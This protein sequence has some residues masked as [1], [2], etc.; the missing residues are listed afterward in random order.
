M[1]SNVALEELLPLHLSSC[2]Y[3][4]QAVHED[5]VIC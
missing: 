2:Q 5:D 3:G 1:L 4:K